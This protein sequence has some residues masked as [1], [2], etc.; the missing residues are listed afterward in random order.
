MDSNKFIL[1][2]KDLQEKDAPFLETIFS[3]ANGHFGVRASNPI[4]DA[5]NFDTL[6]NGFYEKSPIHY[7]ESAYGYAKFNQ[8]IVK[9]TNLR[10]I[11]VTNTDGIDFNRSEL[12][13]MKLNMKNGT[14]TED[15]HLFNTV[16][17]EIRMEI[18]SCISQHDRNWYSISYK[19]TPITY[20]ANLPSV[21]Q[22][23]ST[24]QLRYSIPEIHVNQTFH[25]H[26]QFMENVK[27]TTHTTVF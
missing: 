17:D 27:S 13:S 26:Y 6:V 7:G 19:F 2:L 4:T 1:N 9:V 22:S 16:N 8:T 10:H 5:E 18:T 11:K 15:Y 3:I 20:H 25:I 12:I 21:R 24:P 23:S 14:L